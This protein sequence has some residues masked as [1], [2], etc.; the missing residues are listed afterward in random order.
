[1]HLR[2]I[3]A[4]TWYLPDLNLCCACFIFKLEAECVER[5]EACI[6]AAEEDGV[7]NMAEAT[8]AFLKDFEKESATSDEGAW[9]VCVSLSL[10]GMCVCVGVCV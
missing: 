9:K 7:L 10:V 5:L 2:V 3:C 6:T 4:C 8:Q 1:M